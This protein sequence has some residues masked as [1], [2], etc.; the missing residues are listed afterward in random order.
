VI[1]L[2]AFVPLL[3]GVF[4]WTRGLLA[5]VLPWIL[6]PIYTVVWGVIGF[7]P[8]LAFIVV[9]VIATRYL[10]HFGRLL[11]AEVEKGS[12]V[13]PG[14]HQEWAA[15]TSKLLNA[16]VIVF[17][18]VLVSPHLP[19]FGSPAFQGVSIFLGVLLSL[20]ST[21]AIANL[22]AGTAL[23]YMRPFV[24]G[25]RVQIA[26]TTGDVVEKSMLMTRLRTVKNVEVTIPNAMVLANQMINYSAL[27]AAPGLILHTTV[28]I[29]YDV[30]WRRVDELLRAAATA[31][32]DVE[33][34]PAPF[35]LQTGL[36]DFAVAYELNVY[37]RAVK[38]SARI[39]SHLHR[40]IQ[41]HFAEAHVE[42]L[43]PHFTAVRD[44]SAPALP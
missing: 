9:V 25:D 3:L 29:G 15:P 35:V 11:F 31:T 30:P 22:V 28:T 12:I 38:H 41:D 1:L 32:D 23:I 21:A 16:L 6:A 34:E 14:F 44:G 8:S 24:V 13:F 10:L 26:E 33:A 39:R 36:D 2:Y 20:G 7:L 17:A 4:P 40:H 18:V 5:Q 37:V 27:A 43:S 19:G 42:I